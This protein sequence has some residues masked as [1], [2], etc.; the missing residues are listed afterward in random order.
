MRRLS[1]LATALPLLALLLV[2]SG[3]APAAPVSVTF[4]G[5][6][7]DTAFDKLGVFGLAGADLGGATMQTTIRFDTT[8]PYTVSGSDDQYT[9][10][11]PGSGTITVAITIGGVTLT[12]TSAYA[13]MLQAI[14]VG[15]DTE[16]LGFAAGTPA[17]M[18]GYDLAS[19]AAWSAGMMD[20]SAAFAALLAP[21]DPDQMQ[22]LEVGTAPGQWEDLV[23]I[24]TDPQIIAEPA[25][26]RLLPLALLV[27]GILRLR[28]RP[29]TCRPTPHLC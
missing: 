15:V 1:R 3:T 29:G 16:A 14:S 23:F 11:A 5:V 8:L 26:S 13:G 9:D 24:A 6:M 12:Q 17:D 2:Q 18:L 19:T 7:A 21:L 20:T 22:Y 27:L 25:A 10:T 4:S 28:R